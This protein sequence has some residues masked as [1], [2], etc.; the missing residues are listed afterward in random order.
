[1]SS[2]REI[3]YRQHRVI[4]LDNG[5]KKVY[6][7]ALVFLAAALVGLV[8]IRT[9]SW[10]AILLCIALV[11]AGFCIFLDTT[12]IGSTTTRIIDVSK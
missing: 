8:G 10:F 4:F 1:M 9:K 11:L 6:S 7:T 3:D 12:E 5:S 2:Y